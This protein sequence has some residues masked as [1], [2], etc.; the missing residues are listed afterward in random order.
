MSPAELQTQGMAYIAAFAALVIAGVNAYFTIKAAF[1]AKDAAAAQSRQLAVTDQ[2]TNAAQ[3]QLDAHSEDIKALIGGAGRP[4]ATSL[5][6]HA[7]T[8]KADLTEHADQLADN[9]AAQ[10]SV[11]KTMPID[12]TGLGQI[13]KAIDDAVASLSQNAAPALATATDS[14]AAVPNGSDAPLAMPAT[15]A[16]T[17]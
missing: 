10:A 3:K 8:L 6:D 15:G 14:A 5:T 12:T 7:D 13:H 9:I 2:K 17:P 1:D 16:Q 11:A 4:L